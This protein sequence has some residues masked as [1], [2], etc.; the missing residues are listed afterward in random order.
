VAEVLGVGTT[1]EDWNAI[2][3][4]MF[5]TQ[6]MFVVSH[7]YTHHVH[8][9]L[10]KASG[11]ASASETDEDGSLDEQV[12]EIDADGYAVFHVLTHLIAGEARLQAPRC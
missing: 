8:G 5:Q 9:H 6:L 3:A 10:S 4:L 7:E 2:H 12:V 11:T 1:I